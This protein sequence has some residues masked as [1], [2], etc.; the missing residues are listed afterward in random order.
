MVIP[1]FTIQSPSRPAHRPAH[2]IP[3]EINQSELF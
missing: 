1:V 3:P 2:I